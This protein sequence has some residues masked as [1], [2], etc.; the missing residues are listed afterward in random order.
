M[1]SP[2]S[3]RYWT[4][5]PLPSKMD[6]LEGYCQLQKSAECFLKYEQVE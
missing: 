6:G 1:Y 4:L 5:R 3:T 2:F